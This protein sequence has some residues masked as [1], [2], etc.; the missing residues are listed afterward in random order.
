MSRREQRL[1]ALAAANRVRLGRVE[2]CRELAGMAPGP[3]LERVVAVLEDP[4]PDVARMPVTKLLGAVP[5]VGPVG[6]ARLLRRAR[7]GGVR[8]TV[9][10][11]SAR[12][13]SALAADLV[14]VLDD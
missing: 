3:A 14:G 8:P 7:V 13:A 10:G 2:L 6:A 11:L 4:A 1:V 5:G 12:Q 9:V